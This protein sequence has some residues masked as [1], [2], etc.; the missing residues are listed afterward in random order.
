VQAKLLQSFE[1][2]DIANA[3]LR[4]DALSE[5]G[6]RLLLD[7]RRFDIAVTPDL[8]ATIALS[9]KLVDGAGRVKAARVFERSAPLNVLTVTQA[10]SAFG[11]AFDALARDVVMWTA[12]VR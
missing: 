1:N 9:A 3:P 7:L 10:A 12:A 8:K 2:Y 11:Q 4:G 5:G 6:A